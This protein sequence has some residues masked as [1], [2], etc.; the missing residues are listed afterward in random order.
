MTACAPADATPAR[1][2]RTID[3]GAAAAVEIDDSDTIPCEPRLVLQ[4][5][6][7]RCHR[8]PPLNGAPF[9]LVTYTN[10]VR[11]TPDGQIRQLMIQ[12]LEARRMPLAPVTIPPAARETLLAWLR[13][14]APA[15]L[16]SSCAI[17]EDAKAPDADA[18][19]DA[20][21]PRDATPAPPC[22]AGSEAEPMSPTNEKRKVRVN[23]SRARARSCRAGVPL[24]A[25][26]R[27]RPSVA[28]TTRRPTRP[29]WRRRGG[30]SSP[31]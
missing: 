12:Q 8:R 31:A 5:I 19:A 7:Q 27:W 3:A 2:S 14:G 23:P 26:S 18:R 28:P 20:E 10:I 25:R 4:S 22:D 30:T 15:A 29:R 1:G 11:V 16:P 13:A 17:E 24:A 6:C 9:P 21:E